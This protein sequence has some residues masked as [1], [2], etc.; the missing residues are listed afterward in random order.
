VNL[1]HRDALRVIANYVFSVYLEAASARLREYA[2]DETETNSVRNVSSFLELRSIIGQV[3]EFIVARC[4]HRHS[5]VREAALQFVVKMADR[6]PW[7][8]WSA[9]CISVLLDT[10]Q[11]LAEQ[12]RLVLDRQ[13]APVSVSPAGFPERGGDISSALSHHEVALPF[14]LRSLDASIPDD[15]RVAAALLPLEALPDDSRAIAAAALPLLEIAYSWLFVG[16][17]KVPIELSAVLQRYMLSEKAHGQ[18][19][20]V[21]LGISIAEE[22]A[23]NAVPI[24]HQ[25]PSIQRQPL[26]TARAMASSKIC[27]K[28]PGGD[29]AQRKAIPDS[30]LSL[31][32][33]FEIALKSRYLGEIRGMQLV[34]GV[35]ISHSDSPTLSSPSKKVARIESDAGSH[36]TLALAVGIL[37]NLEDTLHNPQVDWTRASVQDVDAFVEAM[38]RGAAA[39]HILS[40]G[41]TTVAEDAVTLKILQTMGAVAVRCFCKKSLQCLTTAYRW[42]VAGSSSTNLRR[43]VTVEACAVMLS[44]ARAGRGLWHLASS[45]HGS[46]GAVDNTVLF[47]PGDSAARIL[48][49][50]RNAVEDFTDP[51]RPDD[52]VDAVQS[53]KLLVEFFSHIL[54][55]D[56]FN[57]SLVIVTSCMNSLLSMETASPGRS[58][59]ARTQRTIT[60]RFHLLSLGVR[61]LRK[62]IT[63]PGTVSPTS[64]RVLR[65]RIIR[66]S[67]EF[68][69]GA[70]LWTDPLASASHAVDAFAALWEFY[71]II[72]DE[73]K[74]WSLEY[75]AAVRDP[76]ADLHSEVQ[77]GVARAE[78]AVAADSFLLR[79]RAPGAS[80]AVQFYRSAMGYEAVREYAGLPLTVLHAH[81]ELGIFTPSAAP[82][83]TSSTA[84]TAPVIADK[85]SARLSGATPARV[86][87]SSSTRT[88][89]ISSGVLCLLRMLLLQELD[90]LSAWAG[91][92]E[93]TSRAGNNSSSPGYVT[94]AVRRVAAADYRS[95]AR[96]VKAYKLAVRAAWAISP[97]LAIHFRDRYPAAAALDGRR[98]GV[99][100]ICSLV[101]SNPLSL[102]HSWEAVSTLIASLNCGKGGGSGK[103]LSDTDDDMKE[104]LLWAPAPAY[105]IIDIL[106]RHAVSSSR[107]IPGFVSIE[108]QVHYLPGVVRY[109]I[110]S[111]SVADPDVVQFFL[112]QLIQI[113]RRDQFGA[114]GDLLVELSKTSALVC[115]KLVW[116]LE[117]EAV[118]SDHRN[119]VR[120]ASTPGK[121]RA[122]HG[123]CGSL[124]GPDPLPAIAKSLIARIRACLSPAAL[125]YL[126][127][128]THLFN[129][130]TNISAKLRDIKDKD[131]HSLVIAKSLKELSFEAGRLYLPISPHRLVDSI[132]HDSGLPMQSAAKCPYLLVFRTVH[133]EG[134]DSAPLSLI[135]ASTNAPSVIVPFSLTATIP[136]STLISPMSPL[137]KQE[138]DGADTPLT[139]ETLSIATKK[140]RGVGKKNGLFT[141]P[142]KLRFDLTDSS[143]VPADEAEDE[144]ARRSP[145]SVNHDAPAPAPVIENE[146]TSVS[147]S[148]IPAEGRG[149]FQSPLHQRGGTGTGANSPAGSGHFGHGRPGPVLSLD[150]IDA[151]YLGDPESKSEPVAGT[152][153]RTLSLSEEP[154]SPG[155]ARIQR[156]GF[157]RWVPKELTFAP[158][159]RQPS[160]P[161]LPT[162]TAYPH[163]ALDSA[164]SQ[165]KDACIFK[166]YDD[167]RQDALTIQVRLPFLRRLR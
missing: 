150:T 57:T 131:Q 83:S 42:L 90:R 41:E 61:L 18:S 100:A 43:V 72:L 152:P 122:T 112:P 62:A 49:S 126:D 58:G 125:H 120:G 52:L 132:D 142:K 23:T 34:D 14:A 38:W 45:Q 147:I 10:V 24:F 85:P 32:F 161:S 154:S 17:R 68:F 78:E 162:A 136:R 127:D 9:T 19:S 113:L 69:D 130:I 105:A 92:T 51:S 81:G 135:N 47:E 6:F 128:E 121:A 86:H 155:V 27:T 129:S 102:R 15:E 111:L 4:A 145:K 26:S 165:E 55:T 12:E 82:T 118:P 124:E 70:P 29:G 16:M 8:M 89:N 74:V 30:E 98:K 25:S 94:P 95:I 39:A 13:G 44:T 63:A 137:P 64:R 20:A 40:T 163:L 119:V 144:E 75:Q 31:R 138:P 1:F 148:V 65:E 116:L 71:V 91:N 151:E 104:L 146:G 33:A 7:L 109:C 87:D 84:S 110:R 115:H 114:L 107:S 140:A 11:H 167:C 80:A 156:R 2:K 56:A 54:E 3:F 73:A 149:V 53:H 88:S 143:P 164:D 157:Q 21:H 141:I 50:K 28:M 166:V 139:P 108:Q 60:A 77:D 93:V 67:L 160:D 36:S 117:T 35:K 96:D 153:R 22:A 123:H 76:I 97:T 103:L 101:A 59:L 99:S 79:G 158:L 37:N 133:W 159:T 46:A 5:S 106:N 48:H 66:A 134:P